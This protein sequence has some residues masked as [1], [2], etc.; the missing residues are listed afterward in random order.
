MANR[1]PRVGEIR[2]GGR[3]SEV[4]NAVAAAVLDFIKDGNFRFS[5]QDLAEASHIHRTTIYRRWPE[6]ADLMREAMRVHNRKFTIKTRES[7]HDNAEA[8]VRGLARFLSNPTE[9]AINRALFADPQTDES[10][11]AIAYWEPIQ[12]S[13]RDIVVRAQQVG[14]LPVDLDPQAL[15]MTLVSP[16][17]VNTVLGAP[18][19]D[20]K[21]FIEDLIAIARSHGIHR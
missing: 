15:I 20:E 7:W 12:A 5:Y 1:K 13:L 17:L 9:L 21:K 10:R 2:P 8:I 14:E 16:I 18:P 3:T 11:I 6:R 19:G 4:R